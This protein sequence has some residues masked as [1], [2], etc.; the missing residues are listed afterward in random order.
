MSSRFENTAWLVR[1]L[2]ELPPTE[3]LSINVTS[4][5]PLV[6]SDG[7]LNATQRIGRYHI[8]PEIASGGMASIRLG[9]LHVAPSFRRLIAVKQLHPELAGEPALAATLAEEARINACINHPNVVPIFDVIEQ[10][11]E[12]ALVMDYVHG[13]SLAQLLR[14]ANQRNMLMPAN[15][16][17]RVMS[18]VLHGLHAAHTATSVDGQPLNV[19]HRD[20]S[21]QNIIV[22]VD[23]IARV[24][25]F[26]VAKTAYGSSYTSPG[27]VRGKVAY[28]A[29][30]QLRQ[31]PVDCR[32]DTFSAGIVLW[33]LLSGQ[34]LFAAES[35]RP[36]IEKVL[37]APIPPL[38]RWRSDVSRELERV[39]RRAVSRC[40]VERF[41]SA[42]EFAEALEATGP[43]ASRAEIARWVW[44]WGAS[45]LEQRARLCA[46]LEEGTRPFATAQPRPAY[47]KLRAVYGMLK[48]QPKRWLAALAG[49]VLVAGIAAAAVAHM[50]ASL[51]SG[52]QAEPA[53]LPV[54]VAT[55]AP[56]AQC[57]PPDVQRTSH[58]ETNLPPP[59]KPEALQLERAGRPPRQK[60]PPSIRSLGTARRSLGARRERQPESIESARAGARRR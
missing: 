22:G 35:T 30:E 39:V 50:S 10:D 36:T 59:L 33:E 11:R 29:P 43:L 47:R 58:L 12:L 60:P 16:A 28:M 53:R 44:I 27:L 57:S 34:R 32:T 18:D 15:V 17:R 1:F 8:G 51:H 26:G 41:S 45:A 23:G 56:L 24:L 52:G 48:L 6:G 5:S 38:D 42:L 13:E 37:S 31:E 46:D 21:P 55:V 19:V 4:Q 25:D 9:Q 54:A 7:G 40:P 14:S 20:I 49:G 2:I 3:P